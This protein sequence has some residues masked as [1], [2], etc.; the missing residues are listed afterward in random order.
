VTRNDKIRA[1]YTV[2]ITAV[3]DYARKEYMRS[4]RHATDE[5]DFDGVPEDKLAAPEIH[6]PQEEFDFE[7][8]RLSRAINELPLL[9]RRVLAM[10]FIEQLTAPEIAE[11]LG[12]SVNYVYKQ[13]HLA[14][15]KL[16]LLLT[17][18]RNNDGQ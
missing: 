15:Q 16:K 17:E 10:T 12:C 13:K 8:E 9:R 6:I 1:Q 3:T 7:E 18:G 2:Y 4:L 11:R 5:V 14:L